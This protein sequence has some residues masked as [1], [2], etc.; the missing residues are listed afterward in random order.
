MG[1]LGDTLLDSPAE[2]KTLPIR[3]TSMEREQSMT[4]YLN[5]TL[6]KAGGSLDIC[7]FKLVLSTK[8]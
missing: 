5:S 4:I 7:F 2:V 3:N 8:S 1:C 6:I